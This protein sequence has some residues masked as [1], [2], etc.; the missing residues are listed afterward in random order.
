MN[1]RVEYGGDR[2]GLCPGGAIFP[3]CV[4]ASA[5]PPM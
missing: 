4:V 3:A 2:L 5:F 1:E